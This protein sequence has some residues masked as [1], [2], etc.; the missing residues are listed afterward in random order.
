[1]TGR[2]KLAAAGLLTGLWILF[3][4][5][6]APGAVRMHLTAFWAVLTAAGMFVLLWNL[7][8]SATPASARFSLTAL[9]T[10]FTVLSRG[11]WSAAAQGHFILFPWGFMIWGLVLLFMRGPHRPVRFIAGGLLLF[12]AILLSG[13]F[14]APPPVSPSGTAHPSPRLLWR[15]IKTDMT[16]PGWI[17]FL[18]IPV[19]RFRH[20]SPAL[21]GSMLFWLLTGFCLFVTGFIQTLNRT[22][23]QMELLPVF[24]V[25]VMIF[26]SATMLKP[27]LLL[28]TVIPGRFVPA[29]ILL[30]LCPLFNHV[31]MVSAD[32][33]PAAGMIARHLPHETRQAPPRFRT[34]IVTQEAVLSDTV[35]LF[36]F[37][38]PRIRLLNGLDTADGL[39]AWTRFCNDSL[40]P[41]Q[42]PPD[43]LSPLTR[44]R[45]S[46]LWGE[47]G[48]LWL[49]RFQQEKTSRQRTLSYQACHNAFS[50]AI[51]FLNGGPGKIGYTEPL[52]LLAD[53]IRD[54]P[55]LIAY[56]Q[57]S[58]N[59][60]RFCFEANQRLYPLRKLMADTL[61]MQRTLNRMR[62]VHPDDPELLYEQARL[63]L[64]RKIPT[65][66][67][68][69]YD[70][71]RENGLPPE[72]GLEK[73]LPPRKGRRWTARNLMPMN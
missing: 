48:L 56:S 39:Q 21:K 32:L 24:F 60:D 49:K 54:L 22:A 27:G 5:T 1:M 53:E 11:F 59:D 61:R 4:M 31:R 35:L 65:R 34:R 67:R 72:P 3:E 16:V 17:L 33:K 58:V 71:A 70:L 69:H 37:R 52:A 7:C 10:L 13:F 18:M 43:R 64:A 46:H 66:A 2:T 12:S 63:Y 28:S 26:W 62:L 15:L 55:A 40:S 14:S 6:N 42:F 36:R 57:Q 19:I 68:L 44:C 30:S 9:L 8:P 45:L 73:Q 25:P 23:C 29:L 51:R 38:I 20:R 41:E 47:T 50:R